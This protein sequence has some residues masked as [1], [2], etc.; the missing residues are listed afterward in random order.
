MVIYD[1]IK[2]VGTNVED[3]DDTHDKNIC[4]NGRNN[5]SPVYMYGALMDCTLTLMMDI[6]RRISSFYTVIDD[7]FVEI[8]TLTY[9]FHK[10]IVFLIITSIHDIFFKT[11]YDYLESILR[12][13]TIIVRL[14]DIL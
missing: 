12:S 7:E 14:F 9:Q 4:Q 8:N 3:V 11:I 13:I 1:T 10:I 5:Q 2:L 6:V